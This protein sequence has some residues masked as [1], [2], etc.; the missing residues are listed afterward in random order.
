MIKERKVGE[1]KIKQRKA[2][3]EDKKKNEDEKEDE[4]EDEEFALDEDLLSKL[5]RALRKK[6]AKKWSKQR[7]KNFCFSIKVK[8][9]WKLSVFIKI[10]LF[11]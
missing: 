2:A 9:Y 1:G 3:D 7:M 4:K 10:K 8:F 11:H 6:L 5:K